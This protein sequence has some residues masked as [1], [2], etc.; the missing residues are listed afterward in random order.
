M[1]RHSGFT[2]IE[3]MLFLSASA[4]LT[5]L[6]LVGTGLA[7]Q[8]QQYKDAV[9]SF[10]AFVQGEYGRV[11]SVKNQ[12]LD[13][14]EGSGCPI[15]GVDIGSSNPGQSDC[16]IIG[17]YIA[18]SDGTGES[19]DTY[20]VY[21]AKISDEWRYGYGN[22]DGSYDI[23]WGA[24][25]KLPDQTSGSAQVSILMYRDP[26]F[27]NLAIRTSRFAYPSK[28]IGK[29]LSGEDQA[30]ETGTD[31]RSGR[32]FC[33]YDVGWLPA[34]RR[35]VFLTIQPGSSDAVMVGNATEGC[36]SE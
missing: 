36:L 4:I 10:A 15:A 26:D 7:I 31:Q 14:Q 21:A 19:Y 35:S 24:R 1:N 6:L 30:G 18:S 17:R 27:G 29:F 22:A 28:D 16:V 2:I 20:P 23:N 8:Q 12:R 3:V 32:E 13:D 25:A 9:Q 34:Q 11:I 33:I 5:V